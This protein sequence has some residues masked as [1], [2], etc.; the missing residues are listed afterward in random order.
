MTER[1]RRVH[2][3]MAES[4]VKVG[5]FSGLQDCYRLA[6]VELPKEQALA[7]GQM[8]LEM[9]WFGAA[10]RAYEYAGVRIPKMDLIAFGRRALAAGYYDNACIA[11]G[12]ANDAEGRLAC[13]EFA[14]SQGNWDD[15]RVLLGKK[16]PEL[17]RTQLIALGKRAM[18]HGHHEDAWDAFHEAE[19]EEGLVLLRE[20]AKQVKP[21][22]P[23]SD[24][25]W[26]ETIRRRVEAAKAER[27]KE[28]LIALGEEALRR[29]ET[30]FAFPA[31]EAVVAIGFGEV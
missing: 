13:G 5:L 24:P 20:Q 3:L 15:A 2:L 12:D 14:L 25:E 30:K 21:K 16:M 17:S 27:S 22:K 7:C 29:C 28:Q 4:C 19:Y 11:F 31:F 23:I 1:E 26:E 10:Q 18:K 9:L 6:G 8:A